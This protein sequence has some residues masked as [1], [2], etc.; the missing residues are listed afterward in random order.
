MDC[1]LN[2]SDLSLESTGTKSF[3]LIERL[4]FSAFRTEPILSLGHTSPCIHELALVEAEYELAVSSNGR[5]KLS[6]NGFPLSRG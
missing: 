2:L 6:N 4:I 1:I 5:L 3:R